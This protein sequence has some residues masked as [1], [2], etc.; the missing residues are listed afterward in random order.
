MNSEENQT[1]ERK[2]VSIKNLYLDPNNSRFIDHKVY[3]EPD[4]AKIIDDSIQ[5]RTFDFLLGEKRSGID[6]LVKSFKNYGFLEIGQIRVAAL[7]N[8]KYWVLEGNRRVA[9]LKLLQQTYQEQAIDLGKLKPEIFSEI[10]VVIFTKTQEKKHRFITALKS[11]HERKKDFFFSHAQLI[12]LVITKQ[13]LTEEELCNSLE[14]T[15]VELRRNLRTIALI[16][17]YKNSD[18][19]DQFQTDMFGVFSAIITS[20]AIKSWIAWDDEARKTNNAAHT[21]R[22]FALL[23]E[24][25]VLKENEVGE[26]VTIIKERAISKSGEISTLSKIID[27]PSALAALEHH[28][29][30]SEAYFLSG[31]V[32]EDIYER[33]LLGIEQ[34]ILDVRN[35]SSYAND[36]DSKRL[37][38]IIN[39]I[40]D[41]LVSQG[42]QTGLSI[43]QNSTKEILFKFKNQQFKEIT[44]KKFKGFQSAL[45]IQGLSRINLFAGENNTG[46][47]SLLEAIY[48]LANQNDINSLLELY[49]RRGKFTTDFSVDW[50]CNTFQPFELVGDFDGKQLATK[51][52]MAQEKDATINK[53]GYISSLHLESTFETD[54]LY[55]R[56]RLY[57][58]QEQME[59]SFEEVKA[60]C[61]ATHSSPF[62]F[63]SKSLLSQYH[64]KSIK[65][66][67]YDKLIE[68]IKTYIDPKI[69]SITK[70]G[71]NENMRF[72]VKHASFDQAQ[73]ITQ[74]GEG[75]QRIFY[76]SLQIASA[77]NGVMCIDEIENAIHHSLLIRFTEFLQRMAHEFNVQLFITT[78]SNECIKAF[79]ENGYQNEDITGYRLSQT[80]EGIVYQGEKGAILQN[81]IENFSLDLRG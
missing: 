28:R 23:S 53:A 57:H 31:H 60:V 71:K 63:L 12:F 49:K 72:L 35:F 47:T 2:L 22:L 9:A 45:H 3:E 21:E 17:E 24:I 75:V 69:E 46:K 64:E 7:G 51:G 79:F 68:F 25:T 52:W 19:G 66:G 10:P 77:K 27:D 18:Y 80:E 78:H 20:T 41:L 16:E 59:L 48:L 26:G 39:Q 11:I 5:E 38:K 62:T 33:A 58:E 30:I 43:N 70:V 42:I 15:K 56:A 36:V 8:G 29:D 81:Q 65:E 55:S 37:T 76:I 50:F 67:T 34:N 13:Y 14:I 54:T 40:Q 1:Q 44:L 74:F 4:D 73:D 61:Y 32:G 6:D